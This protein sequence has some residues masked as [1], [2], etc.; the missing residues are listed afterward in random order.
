MG[1]TFHVKH[2]LYFNAAKDRLVAED[3][4]ESAFL[5]AAAGREIPAVQA[6]HLGLIPQPNLKEQRGQED[7]EIEVAA[8]KTTIVEPEV[9]RR[10]FGK[11]ML[12]KK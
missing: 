6:Q 9:K 4:P 11:L 12:R 5:F 1:D 3:S 2:R 7:K 10:R 8:T